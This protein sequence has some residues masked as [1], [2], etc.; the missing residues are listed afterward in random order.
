M[1]GLTPEDW[2]I[3]YETEDEFQ[4]LFAVV[5]YHRCEKGDAKYMH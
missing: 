3:I 5:P 1:G 2:D 4:V